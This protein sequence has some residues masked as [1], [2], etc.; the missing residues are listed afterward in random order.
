MSGDEFHM[1]FP[2]TICFYCRLMVNYVYL[3]LSI[4]LSSA[5]I[6]LTYVLFV[7]YFLLSQRFKVVSLNTG[8]VIIGMSFAPTVTALF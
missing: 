2:L 1:S 6:L 7:I 3:A 5:D 4:Y 8:N